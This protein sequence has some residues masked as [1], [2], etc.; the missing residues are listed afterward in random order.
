MWSDI[1]NFGHDNNQREFMVSSGS[2]CGN[3]GICWDPDSYDSLHSEFFVYGSSSGKQIYGE[4][5]YDT[6]FYHASDSGAE[7]QSR[8]SHMLYRSCRWIFI[9]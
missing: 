8:E 5:F 9:Q 1:R 2:G 6:V 3:R 7:H 4:V